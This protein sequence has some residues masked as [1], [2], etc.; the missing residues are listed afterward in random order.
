MFQTD[1]TRRL[2]LQRAAATGAMLPFAGCGAG[3]KPFNILWITAEDMSPHMSCYGE[4]A[5]R[6]PNAD[7]LAAEGARF[8]RAFVTSPTCSPSRSAVITGM[9]QTTIGAH[10]H[11]SSR[12]NVKIYL[13]EHI[14]LIP[15]YFQRAGYYTTLGGRID[16]KLRSEYLKRA[17]PLMRLG[18]SDYNFVWPEEVYDGNDWSGRKSGQP[19]FAQ[20][21][22]DGGKNRGAKLPSP[23]DPDKVKLPPY[24][25]DHPLLRQD[26]A[27]YLNSVINMDI[28]LGRVLQRLEDEKLADNTIVFFFT[29]HGVDDARGK[30]FLYDSG[31]QIPLIIRWP[32]T[33]KPGTVRQDMVSHID[34]AATSLDMA[35]IQIPEY[36]EG[37]PLFGPAY[38]PREHIFSGR[39][40]TD[41]TIDRI[42][43]VRDQ[44]FKYIR[45]YYPERSHMVAARYHEGA[46]APRWVR[47]MREL[48]AQGKLEPVPAHL[49]A[50]TRPAEELYDVLAD[51]HEINNLAGAPEHQQTIERLRSLLDEWLKT[52][53]GQTAESE[54]SLKEMTRVGNGDL[55]T[56]V[57]KRYPSGF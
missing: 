19:F 4:T 45:N 46:P 17:D 12:G 31:I 52:D 11:R 35:G 1:R 48:H 44:R 33:I 39:D 55:R 8:E 9:Y 38:K 40:R 23:A 53:K 21:H 30:R 42:R 25:A 15:E 13:P 50:S 37:R 41:T 24:W 20:I 54:E 49:F 29:D 56:G 18:K 22:L 57:S 47:I 26:W 3:K 51:P 36:M 28:E 43:C 27:N 32:G 16:N 6:T 2:F 10:N 14:K 34:I 5:I 7:R